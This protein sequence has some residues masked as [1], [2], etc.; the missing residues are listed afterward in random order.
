MRRW[1]NQDFFRQKNKLSLNPAGALASPPGYAVWLCRLAMPSGY[2]VWLCRLAMPPGFAAWLRRL[3]SPS[4]YAVW[5]RRLAMPSGYAVWLCRTQEL[6]SSLVTAGL[7]C[8]GKISKKDRGFPVPRTPPRV[9]GGARRG[10][11]L[12]LE[13][14]RDCLAD[15]FQ[16][17][18]NYNL[19]ALN[20]VDII[21][22]FISSV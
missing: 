14:P 20:D 15:S 19:Q 4:G 13:I 18:G 9:L 17:D 2:A 7:T 10:E 6:V 11:E 8:T 5:L 16:L 22:V 21:T 12:Q 3:A 1:L